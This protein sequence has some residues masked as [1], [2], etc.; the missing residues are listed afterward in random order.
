VV[1][2]ALVLVH[3]LLV[4]VLLVPVLLVLVGQ[5]V[6]PVKPAESRPLTSGA[7]FS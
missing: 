3:L 7:A 1:A 5:A 6:S 4:P 2:L